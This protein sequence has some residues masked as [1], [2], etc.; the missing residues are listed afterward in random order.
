MVAMTVCPHRDDLVPNFKVDECFGKSEQSLDKKTVGTHAQVS[1][2]VS[3]KFP[4]LAPTDR[5]LHETQRRRAKVVTR[6]LKRESIFRFVWSLLD[7]RDAAN[8]ETI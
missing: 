4:T 8:D 5:P 3:P 1:A 2:Q 6:L 7:R